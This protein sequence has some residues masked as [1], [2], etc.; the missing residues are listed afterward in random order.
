PEP[1]SGVGDVNAWLNLLRLHV[2]L[3]HPGYTPDDFAEQIV[4]NLSGDALKWAMTHLTSDGKIAISTDDFIAE[5]KANFT[6]YND[7]QLAE[8]ELSRLRLTSTVQAFITAFNQVC[9]RI[10]KMT[11]D[12]KRRHFT[13]GLSPSLQRIVNMANPSSFV[14]ACKSALT[15]ENT[16]VSRASTSASATTRPTPPVDNNAMDVDVF[17]APRLNKLTDQDRAYLR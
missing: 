12:E 8:S 16:Y 1:Y 14:D 5:L 6:A 13:E 3:N 9:L 11:D 2:R 17:Q 10:P 4:L 7:K 15:Q